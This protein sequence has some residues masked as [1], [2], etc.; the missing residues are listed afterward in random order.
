MNFG[1]CQFVNS[2]WHKHLTVDVHNVVMYGELLRMGTDDR[3]TETA[4]LLLQKFIAPRFEAG[5]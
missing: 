5:K 2:I 4:D 1:E 3:L